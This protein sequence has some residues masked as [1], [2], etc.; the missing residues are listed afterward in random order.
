MN[1]SDFRSRGRSLLGRALFRLWL[2][3]KAMPGLVR[4]GTDYG[5]WWVPSSCLGPGTVAYCGGAGEDISFDV[6]L[7]DSGCKVVTFDPTPRAIAHVRD[8][9]PKD[10]RFRFVPVGWWGEE[11]ELRFYAPRNPAH[12]SHSAVNLQRT[13]EYFIAPVKPVRVLMEELGDV[14]VD[15]IKMDVEGSEYAVIDSLLAIGPRVAV[16]CIE[17]DQPQPFRRVLTAVHRLCESGYRLA[18]IERWNYTF[19]GSIGDNREP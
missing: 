13:E 9:A 11:A 8:V 6:A 7:H 17:F 4:L 14:R 12:V 10:E 19:V 3:P 18:K 16:L 2:R 15:L 1:V 5:G